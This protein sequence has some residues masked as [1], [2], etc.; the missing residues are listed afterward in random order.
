M[1]EKEEM[2][3]WIAQNWYYILFIILMIIIC[4]YGVMTGKAIE[5][6]KYAVTVAEE[7]LG[8]GTG[9]LKLREV[10]DMFLE[11]FP[12]FSTLVPFPVFSKLVDVALEWLEIQ[13]EKNANVKAIVR[14]E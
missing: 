8:S 13:L 11:K 2:I 14:G 7:H 10:Y 4:I 5:W 1:K 9:Q 3:D 12:M 6:L